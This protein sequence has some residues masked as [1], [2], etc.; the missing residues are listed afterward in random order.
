MGL[1]THAILPAVSAAAYHQGVYKE[2]I[3]AQLRAS[4]K[5][6]SLRASAP[7]FSERSSTGWPLKVCVV[8]GLAMLHPLELCWRCWIFGHLSG[9]QSQ[10][11]HFNKKLDG[12]HA[13]GNLKITTLGFA[14]GPHFSFMFLNSPTSELG[15]KQAGHKYMIILFW[16]NGEGSISEKASVASLAATQPFKVL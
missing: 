15:T 3:G 9:F 7:C 10:S 2:R 8:C 13:Q 11:L 12:S 1:E 14:L 6:E 16:E 5:K 4:F